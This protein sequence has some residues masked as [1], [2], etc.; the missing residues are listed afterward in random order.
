MPCSRVLFR[1]HIAYRGN[2]TSPGFH[3]R[4]NG[5]PMYAL[6]CERV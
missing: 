6:S 5:L 3:F 2:R 1:K 4:G